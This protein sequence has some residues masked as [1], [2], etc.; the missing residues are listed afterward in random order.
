MRYVVFDMSSLVFGVS[1][2]GS[3][4]SV[5]TADRVLLGSIE[6]PPGV[7]RAEWCFRLLDDVLARCVLTERQNA[8]VALYNPYSAEVAVGAVPHTT[9]FSA[10]TPLPLDAAGTDADLD[11]G[12]LTLAGGEQLSIIEPSLEMVTRAFR[13]HPTPAH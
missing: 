13:A 4:L 7:S 12:V 9:V 8:R 2:E 1:P 10:S 3:T 11:G 6:L 5:R